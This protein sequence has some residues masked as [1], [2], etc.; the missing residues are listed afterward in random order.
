MP[1]SPLRSDG[2]GADL[3][4]GR[5]LGPRESMSSLSNEFRFNKVF[6]EKVARLEKLG[7]NGWR[8]V[9]G[10][11]NCFYR[12]V[13]FGMLEQ[14]LHAPPLRRLQLITAFR[15][16]L[17]TI[18]WD[19]AHKATAHASLL[20]RLE[21]IRVGTTWTPP[22]PGSDA[23]MC[24][25]SLLYEDMRNNQAPVDMALIRALRKLA[26]NYIIENAD[27]NTAVD[28]G[29]T[30]R[31][32]A[33]CT[34]YE[35][36]EDFCH[37]V[38]LPEGEDAETLCQHALPAALDIVVRVAFLDRSS[39]GAEP[40]FLDFG[41]R[42][43]HSK[44][45]SASGGKEEVGA[46][47]GDRIMVNIQFRPGHYDLLYKAEAKPVPRRRRR[48]SSNVLFAASRDFA[49]HFEVASPTPSASQAAMPASGR[50]SKQ[51][52]CS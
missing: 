27:C 18:S 2:G 26:A 50:R 34:G 29:I 16:R 5:N 22:M 52:L 21:R 1:A 42:V 31:D 33:M 39:S 24:N 15:E 12:S 32:V 38:V 9:R 25:Q 20:E 49:N 37:R 7:Y 3:I 28:S 13:G 48:S 19:E 43:S 51:G 8:R 10:D 45:D 17:Q 23:M 44:E 30:F 47:V 14:I 35:S 46:G 40:D 11:G 6:V 36:V 4:C 41:D